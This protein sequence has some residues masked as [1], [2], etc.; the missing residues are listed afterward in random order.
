MGMND[1]TLSHIRMLANG[2]ISQANQ[3][4][5]WAAAVEVRRTESGALIKVSLRPGDARPDDPLLELSDLADAIRQELRLERTKLGK[6]VYATSESTFEAEGN[7]SF[8]F[9]VWQL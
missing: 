4:N 1:K 5:K 3:E 9:E 7:P 8:A 6:P 2:I